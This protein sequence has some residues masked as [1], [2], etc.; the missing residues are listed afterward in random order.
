MDWQSVL[1]YNPHHDPRDG[2]FTFGPSGTHADEGP[3]FPAGLRPFDLIDIRDYQNKQRAEGLVAKEYEGLSTL[4]VERRLLEKYPGKVFNLSAGIPTH[5]R[6]VATALDRMA[7]EYP[8][9]WQSF[10]G[11]SI[12]DQFT[13]TFTQD[14]HPN[15]W[16]EMTNDGR[17]FLNPNKWEMKRQLPAG[18]GIL[19]NELYN[20]VQANWH[21][22]GCDDIGS[23]VT[24]E[25]GHHFLDH[26]KNNRDKTVNVLV[27]EFRQIMLAYPDSHTTV[28]D[29]AKVNSNEFF[30]EVFSYAHGK[31]FN[32]VVRKEFEAAFKQYL[33]DYPSFV[34]DQWK[35][36][37]A[38]EERAKKEDIAQA[39]LDQAG[40]L[41][42]EMG[43]KRKKQRF[44]RQWQFGT[45]LK[46][47]PNHDKLGRFARATAVV[48]D[49]IGKPPS[50]VKQILRGRSV[51]ALRQI[52]Q[53]LLD[54][55]ASLMAQG[56]SDSMMRADEVGG[57]RYGVATIR[58]Q[59]M[60]RNAMDHNRNK[61]T[62]FHGTNSMA[63]ESILTK[64]LQA[65]PGG[66]NYASLHYEGERGRSVY[67]VSREDS[68]E[69][70]AGTAARNAG[71]P[72]VLK[73]R[74]PKEERINILPDEM[75]EGSISTF[76]I[77][78][79]IPPEW[80]V[81]YKT[82]VG[83]EE[84]PFTEWKSAK[85]HRHSA[86]KE[87]DDGVFYVVVVCTGT[88]VQMNARKEDFA[89]TQEKQ[90]AAILKFNP[91]HADDGKFTTAQ[92]AVQP[93]HGKLGT[94]EA[95]NRAMQIIGMER[96]E[97][98]VMDHLA[99]LGREVQ[100]EEQAA[101]IERVARR[102]LAKHGFA[103]GNTARKEDIEMDM[104]YFMAIG[105]TYRYLTKR[106]ND[107][108]QLR[109]KQGRWAAIGSG[110]TAPDTPEFKEWFGNSKVVDA[111]GNP[112]RVFH[113]TNSDVTEFRPYS[114]FGTARAANDRVKNLYG[115]STHVVGRDPGQ[116]QSMPLYLS[117]Q[118]P[119]RLP[120]LATISNE[121][122]EVIDPKDP[123]SKG[124]YAR[125]WEGEEDLS[126][127]LLEQ[128]IIDI[129]EFEDH[130]S[131]KDAFK[132][133]EEKG[134]DGIV[135]R[136]VVEDYGHDS[137]IIFHPWQ[138]KSASGNSGKYTKDGHISKRDT[139][140][141]QPRDSHGRWRDGTGMYF[142]DSTE[143]KVWR[144]GGDHSEV[145]ANVASR[146]KAMAIPP[147]SINVHL[148]PDPDAPMQATWT[149]KNGK[150][151]YKYHAANMAE[152]AAEKF[153]RLKDFNAALPKL[154]HHAM[155]DMVGGKD[156]ATRDTAAVVRLMDKTGFRVGGE[157]EFETRKGKA[158]GASTLLDEHVV[159]NGTSLT[160]KFPGKHA[161]M[162][163]HEIKDALLAQYIRAR[164]RN[165]HKEDRLFTTSE[166]RINAYMKQVTGD[167]FSAKDF[168]TWHGTM[169]ALRLLK[170]H[171]IG[172]EDEYR[173]V[174][175]LVGD[176]VS[177]HLGNTRQVA[178]SSYI[179]PTV[180]GKWLGKEK[181]KA[182]THA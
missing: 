48:D 126:V 98:E 88:S 39:D 129:D 59:V 13:Q 90:Y 54:Y 68:A 166:G 143:P 79:D 165:T 12:S 155:T 36:R 25:F 101:E 6:E 93:G 107:G 137:Y 86:H 94:V 173:K 130:R 28:G 47:N 11:I 17:M 2:R 37:E 52:E 40:R 147:A 89:G 78:R 76:R 64:G 106:D 125:E 3:D 117:L 105:D 58:D 99:S 181:K 22:V 30:A 172:S 177:S 83:R 119:L 7:N 61:A 170:T 73:L 160:F 97:R 179:D 180:W 81:S 67:M 77:P 138:V 150:L 148:N 112:M 128:K 109:D 56:D 152:N 42:P 19:T 16:A 121:T 69:S 175:V 50:E 53:N 5:I 178:L 95:M 70:W 72:M 164:K 82:Y 31:H 158:Y 111:Q 57:T 110:F 46:F 141:T 169:T 153:S 162:Q 120:D 34:K 139:D 66:R 29:Y 174:R 92:N 51:Q 114:H 171:P 74:I 140:G 44:K 10:K 123:R 149:A 131:T 20:C 161:V 103:L 157:H 9:Q 136:N 134:Y 24:H 32:G 104:A 87:E 4:A 151:Q 108:T 41:N 26:E 100:G 167:S 122:G 135:Y 43:P 163:E 71:N 33:T 133:L 176:K 118:N 156:Q 159:V 8:E 15:A 55:E 75:I 102:I 182:K 49:I 18:L 91:N 62:F 80:I 63:L 96:F 113:G 21:P 144:Y 65:N 38:R 127:T 14:R 23:V 116:F 145:P 124:V 132:L 154:R 115:F 45:V 85:K 84:K 168:R 142:D 60:W 1:K 35:R 146:L 27:A